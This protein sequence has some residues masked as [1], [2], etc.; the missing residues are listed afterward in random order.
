MMTIVHTH[1]L[2]HPLVLE[3]LLHFTFGPVST[4]N[5]VRAKSL[6]REKSVFAMDFV[7]D[8]KAMSRISGNN[9]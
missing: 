7:D 4:N 5:R 2:G 3:G 1:I 9:A 6:F 8:W